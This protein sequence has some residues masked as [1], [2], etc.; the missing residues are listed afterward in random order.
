MTSDRFQVTFNAEEKCVS[1]HR[2]LDQEGHEVRAVN[3]FLDASAA[4]GLSQRTLRTY[5]YA[6]MSVWHWLAA[7]GQ[8][9]DQLTEAHLVQ[10]VAFMRQR[11]GSNAQPAPK[12]INLRLSVLRALFRF[13]MGCDLPQARRVPRSPPTPVN[14]AP[15]SEFAFSR[16]MRRRARAFHVRVPR[17]LI[18]PLT[19]DEVQRFF[20]DLRT[21]RDMAIVSLML[22]CGLRSREVIG[23]KEE[24]LDFEHEQIRILGKGEKDRVLPLPGEARNAIT[25]YIKIE[26]PSTL[27]SCIFVSLKGAARGRPM[28]PSGLRSL[29]RHHRMASKT[30]RANAHR[31]RHTFASDMVRGGISL[32]VLMRLMGHSQ[33]QMTLRYVHLSADDIREEFLKAIRNRKGLSDS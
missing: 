2:L 6:L 28:T 4:R 23:L 10:Y 19:R 22:F 27:H 18:V 32:P 14:K 3:E 21:W 5:A 33:I 31:F 12:S 13:L 9:I 26:R 8:V 30:Y 15:S 11:A 20:L 17:K 25:S 29:F 1:P 24:D 7:S 16:R